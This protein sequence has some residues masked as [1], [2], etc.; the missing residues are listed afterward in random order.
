M[1]NYPENYCNTIN[2]TP[3]PAL[4]QR[5]HP[6]TAHPYPMN[7]TQA[8]SPAHQV[9]VTY[10]GR[11]YLQ[12]LSPSGG[13]FMYPIQQQRRTGSGWVNL[14]GPIVYPTTHSI[15]G[16]YLQS[17]IDLEANKRSYPY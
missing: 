1:N 9:I 8:P 13:P 10:N 2:F 14:N 7:F 17:Y 15:P 16:P 11:Q 5:W 12:G 6:T 3:T 4:N